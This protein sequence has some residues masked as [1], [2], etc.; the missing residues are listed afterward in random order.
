ME[1]VGAGVMEGL[2]LPIVDG[3]VGNQPRFGSREQ[4]G[5]GNSSLDSWRKRLTA[6]CQDL[7]FRQDPWLP[8][9]RSWT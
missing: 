7:S 3:P 5:L 6:T 1:V 9:E 4:L 2:V 8:P